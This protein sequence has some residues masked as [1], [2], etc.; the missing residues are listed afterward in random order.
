MSQGERQVIVVANL[1]LKDRFTNYHKTINN[2]YVTFKMQ[3]Q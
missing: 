2:D 1:L 3:I